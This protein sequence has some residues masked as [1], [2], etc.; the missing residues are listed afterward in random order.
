[1]KFELDNKQMEALRKFEN[2]QYDE[3]LKKLTERAKT[4]FPRNLYGAI[5]GSM[6][7]CFTRTSIGTIVVV[8]HCNGSELDLTDYESF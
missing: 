6:T 7:V 5:G 1:M 2:E 3:D 4:P 8:K